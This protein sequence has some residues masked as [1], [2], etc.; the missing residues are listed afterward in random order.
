MLKSQQQQQSQSPVI[1]RAFN[2]TVFKRWGRMSKFASAA[3]TL[4]CGHYSFPEMGGCGSCFVL[5]QL[6][7]PVINEGSI[8]NCYKAGHPFGIGGTAQE[9]LAN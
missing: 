8:T 3:A 5:Q 1:N 6:H 4:A 2:G 7:K 9:M